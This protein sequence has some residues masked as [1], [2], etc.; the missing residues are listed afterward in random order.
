MA[1]DPRLDELPVEVFNNILS[2]LVYPR[3]RLPGL[4]ELQSQ[5]DYDLADK[6]IAK[7]E[8]HLNPTVIPDRDRF[9]ANLFARRRL[10][11]PFNELAST[12]RR[13]RQL[14]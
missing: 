4:T 13:L 10:C 6:R 7:D 3:S 14:D 5:H 12:S 11:H 9:G 2:F 1:T 8:Y